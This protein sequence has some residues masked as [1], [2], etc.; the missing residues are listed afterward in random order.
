MNNATI[1]ELFSRVKHSLDGL[2]ASA[3]EPMVDFQV[4]TFAG[5]LSE[6][7]GRFINYCLTGVVDEMVHDDGGTNG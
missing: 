2:K 1:N 4:I 3:T 5:A 7:T 6:H